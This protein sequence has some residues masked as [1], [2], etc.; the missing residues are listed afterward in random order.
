MKFNGRKVM[1]WIPRSLAVIT[2]LLLIVF[3]S[4]DLGTYTYARVMIATLFLLTMIV[5]WRSEPIGGGFFVILGSLY[6]IVAMG[7]QLALIYFLGAIPFFVVGS[8]FIVD[9]LYQE[10]KDQQ[11]EVDF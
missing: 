9:Y 10:K 11:Q 1:F 3:V 7:M 8:L 6:L 5:S 4:L 2:F